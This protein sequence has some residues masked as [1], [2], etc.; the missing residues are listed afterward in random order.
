[1]SALRSLAVDSE[2]RRITAAWME[3]SEE[4]PIPFSESGIAPF[5]EAQPTAPLVDSTPLLP[6]PAELRAR[7]ERDGCVYFAQLLPVAPVL[8]LRAD[9]VELLHRYH[10]LDPEEEQPSPLATKAL[11]VPLGGKIGGNGGPPLPEFHEFMQAFQQLEKL[12]TLPHAPALTAVVAAVLGVDEAFV[13]PRH[14]L[15]LIFPRHNDF[16]TLPHQDWIHVQGA[17][18]T[19]TAWLPLGDVARSDGALTVLRGSS[20]FGLVP[21]YSMAQL[22]LRGGAG[23]IGCKVADLQRRGCDWASA[24]FAPGDCLLFSSL[25]AHQGL[26]HLG[27]QLRKSAPLAATS[28]SQPPIATAG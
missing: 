22:G 23:G 17:A 14:I 18:E 8:A 3:E 1:M 28:N 15:R 19:L 21:H 9:L 10:W 4:G 7:Y 26:P 20:R 2:G 25:C 24:D 16:K 13:H 12:H 5:D 6:H 27:D 11:S